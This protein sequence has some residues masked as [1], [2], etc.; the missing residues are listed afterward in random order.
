MCRLQKTVTETDTKKQETYIG[1]TENKFKTRFNLHKSSFKLE[2]KRTTTILS[3][4]IWKLKKKN[5][6]SNIK[7]EIIKNVKPYAPGEK[8]CKLCLQEQFSILI[9]KPSL[10]KRTEILDTVCTENKFLL[11][12]IKYIYI[13]I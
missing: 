8:I 13:Y 4:H 10:N 9:S 11:N 1:L 12:T 2:H 3:D 6:D 7:W 5:T